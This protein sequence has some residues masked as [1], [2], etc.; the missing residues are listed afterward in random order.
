MSVLQVTDATFEQQVLQSELPVLVDLYAD[1]CQPCK[2]LAP[3][4]AELSTELEGKVLFV[5]VDVDRSPMIAQSF[6]VQSIP[7]LVVIHQ[8]QVAGH[9]LGVLDKKGI[10]QLLEPVLPA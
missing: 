8:G 7:M 1:W 4:L 2:Q 9:H 6:R 10:L 5:Q 3:I